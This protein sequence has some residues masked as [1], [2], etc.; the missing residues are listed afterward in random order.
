M[1]SLSFS[2]KTRTVTYG[3]GRKFIEYQ[4]CM[5]DRSR[6]VGI[7]TGPRRQTV[8]RAE[9]LKAAR[10]RI[11]VL[12]KHRLF[13]VYV[14]RKHIADGE[15][16]SCNTCAISQALWHSQE[17]MGFPKR[18][19][20]FRTE[21]YAC[22]ADAG[23]IILQKYWGDRISNVPVEKLPEIVHSIR[24]SGRIYSEGMMEWTMRWDDWAESR[25]M[26]LKEWRELHSAEP[27]E[28]PYKPGPISFVL[29]LDELKPC[30]A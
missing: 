30:P 17:K 24:P 11:S 10:T 4:I 9:A 23:G 26:P 8:T 27:D 22:F 13:P 16:R 28:R 1:K 5:I 12:R 20:C 7:E 15:A 25:Y 29:D 14:T 21:T 2:V 19:Y 3:D 6:I 18:E